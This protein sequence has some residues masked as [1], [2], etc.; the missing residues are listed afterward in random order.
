MEPLKV[1]GM[2]LAASPIGEHDKRVVL[3]ARAMIS[4]RR[5][6]PF[7]AMDTIISTTENMHPRRNTIPKIPIIEVP[8][9]SIL[10]PSFLSKCKILLTF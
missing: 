10:P 1:T 6:S 5:S 9:L 7:W 2:V 8:P 3:L 4:R